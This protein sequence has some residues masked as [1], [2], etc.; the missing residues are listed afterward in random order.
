M[1]TK[2]YK[3]TSPGIRFQSHASF[4]G[5]TDKNVVEDP[6]HPGMVEGKRVPLRYVE[7][8]TIL[9]RKDIV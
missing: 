3:P 2:N 6:A 1:A 7:K 5:L 4:E 8:T 9:Q